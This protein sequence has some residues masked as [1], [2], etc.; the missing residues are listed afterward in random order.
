MKRFYKD[1]NMRYLLYAVGLMCMLLPI[2]ASADEMKTSHFCNS[3]KELFKNDSCPSAFDMSIESNKS[4][5]QWK[6]EFDVKNF[7]SQQ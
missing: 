4:D 1:S 5:H 7:D 6:V 2:F 3:T